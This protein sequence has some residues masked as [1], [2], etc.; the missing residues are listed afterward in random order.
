M[1]RFRRLREGDDGGFTL[2]ELL[3]AMALFSVLSTVL[4]STLASTSKALTVTRST[5]GIN[6]GARLTFNRMSRELREARSI[7]NVGF[8]PCGGS[9]PVACPSGVTGSVPT[10]LTFEDDFNGNGVI[11]S[12]GSDPEVLTYCW[13]YTNRRILLTPHLPTS[14][15]CSD[16]DAL[17]VLTTDVESFT[18]DLR[19]SLWQYDS[20]ADGHTTWQELDAA[21][22]SAGVGNQ[23]GTLDSIELRN[24]DSVVITMTVFKGPRR[25]L[26]RTQVNLRNRP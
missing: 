24:I 14:S 21:P 7:D 19:S 2:V 11:D 23:N 22:L 5:V 18:L 16:P 4:V 1:N 12:S 15:D 13:D 25:Q 8:S 9:A 3:V 20:N 10:S 26:Y 17:P 6:E